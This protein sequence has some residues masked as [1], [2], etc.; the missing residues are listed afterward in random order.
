MAF[1]VMCSVAQA[2]WILYEISSDGQHWYYKSESIKRNG[3][4][5]VMWIM[6][7]GKMDSINGK[8]YRSVKSFFEFNCSAEKQRNVTDIAYSDEMGYG[9]TVLMNHDDKISWRP[10]SPDSIGE[11]SLK[12]ACGKK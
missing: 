12:I 6:R 2:D 4:L 10:V 7:S 9:D 11:L 3:A 5:S 8:S 1:M